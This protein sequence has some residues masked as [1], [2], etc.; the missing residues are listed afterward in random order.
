[1]PQATI[2]QQAANR[3]EQKGWTKKQDGCN[4]LLFP[5]GQPIHSKY[6]HLFKE[7]KSEQ[8]KTECKADVIRVL[9]K[10]GHSKKE[11]IEL[12]LIKF[13]DCSRVSI[14]SQVYTVAKKV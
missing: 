6:Q 4:F 11:T 9:L 3:L 13:P 10:R 2:D 7:Q 8:P 5:P 1:M 12:M 14:S